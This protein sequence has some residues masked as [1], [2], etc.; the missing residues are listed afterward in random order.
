MVNQLCY[1]TIDNK[2]D[3]YFVINHC[4]AVYIPDQVS[5]MALELSNY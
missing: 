1:D 3:I 5:K 2:E 4:S